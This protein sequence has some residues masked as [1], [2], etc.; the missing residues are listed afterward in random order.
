[1]NSSEVAAVEELSEPD[2]FSVI[3]SVSRGVIRFIKKINK[4]NK[5]H[6]K[7]PSGLGHTHFSFKSKCSYGYVVH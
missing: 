5:K 3:S 4:K 7:S 2:V 6:G 1:M